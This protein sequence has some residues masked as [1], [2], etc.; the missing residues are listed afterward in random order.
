MAKNLFMTFIIIFSVI[1]CSN[2]P[3]TTLEPP[4]TRIYES[5]QS[6]K[7]QS[8]TIK[9]Y[10]YKSYYRYNKAMWANYNKFVPNKIIEGKKATVLCHEMVPG[11]GEL[12]QHV[13]ALKVEGVPETIYIDSSDVAG[14]LADEKSSANRQK[15]FKDFNSL[16]GNKVWAQPNHSALIDQVDGSTKYV[17]LRNIEE[18]TVYNVIAHEETGVGSNINSYVQIFLK[19]STGEIVYAKYSIKYGSSIFDLDWHTI[20]PREIYKNWSS[21]IWKQIEQGQVNLGMTS[22]MV[23][24]AIGSPSDIN[25]TETRDGTRSQWVYKSFTGSLNFYYFNNGILEAIQD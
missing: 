7:G 15:I 17:P 1:A 18:L 5:P 11:P 9:K 23:R 25:T 2:A 8:F 3:K 16:M 19:R 20:N 12:N 10:S 6:Y 13:V 4:C 14:A 22:S 24:L 21:E